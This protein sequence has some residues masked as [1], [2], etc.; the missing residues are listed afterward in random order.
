MNSNVIALLVVCIALVA[1]A[2]VRDF[3]P[4]IL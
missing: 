1:A 4:A 2:G 3:P